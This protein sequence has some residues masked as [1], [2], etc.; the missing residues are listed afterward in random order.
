MG[1]K[2]RRGLTVSSTLGSQRAAIMR[3]ARAAVSSE[4]QIREGPFPSSRDC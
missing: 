1:Q 4:A 3:V 2:L